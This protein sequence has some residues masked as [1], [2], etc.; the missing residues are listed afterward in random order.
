MV[1]HVQCVEVHAGY[2]T[3]S[4]DIAHRIVMVCTYIALK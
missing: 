4:F 2:N 1:D 3:A